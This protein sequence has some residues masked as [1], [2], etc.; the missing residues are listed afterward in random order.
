MHTYIYIAAAEVHDMAA[1]AIAFGATS[2]ELEAS[3]N[4]IIIINS[5]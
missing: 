4:N 2:S 5:Y 3:L 1:V